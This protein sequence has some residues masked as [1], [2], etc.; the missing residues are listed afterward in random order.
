MVSKT[1]IDDLRSMGFEVKIVSPRKLIRALPRLILGRAG[2]TIFTHGPGPRTVL[3]SYLLR[4]LSPTCLI[5]VATRTDLKKLPQWLKNRQTAHYVICT[6]KRRDLAEA[7][8]DAT[9]IEQP[10]GI[11]P[12]RL[13]GT[14]KKMWPE[15]AAIGA[16][17]AVHVGHLRQTR[18][19]DRLIEA[20]TRLGPKI[21]IMIVASPYFE[22][23][24]GLLDELEAAGVHVERGFVE[25]IANVYKSA[26]LYL[27]PVPPESEGAIELP[28]S[29]L[30]A[31]TCGLP[32]I[33]TRFGALPEA[34]RDASGVRFSQSADFAETV[35]N[36]IKNRD[37][38][39]DEGLPEHLNAHRLAE[40][41]SK[42]I[43]QTCPR[44]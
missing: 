14:H 6:K 40:Q 4:L 30:E 24:A 26:D 22:P 9:A 29:V 32:V 38:S 13:H 28:L 15:L 44:D 5:W 37:L 36:Y 3:A 39:N 10:I 27:F 25:T 17:I 31:M 42:V 41:I 33:S 23:E 19:L 2:Y 12:E 11:A 20:K 43:D 21:E 16:P 8:K 7:A 35:E 18:G 34:L 1:L